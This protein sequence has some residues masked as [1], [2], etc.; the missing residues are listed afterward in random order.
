[1]KIILIIIIIAALIYLSVYLE[2]QISKKDNILSKFK[3]NYELNNSIESHDIESLLI[4]SLPHSFKYVGYELVPVHMLKAEYQFNCLI[5]Y[6]AGSI[7]SHSYQAAMNN[8]NIAYQSYQIANGAYQ[9]GLEAAMSRGEG[10]KYIM[11]NSSPSKPSKPDESDYVSYSSKMN[12]MSITEA[13]GT[14]YSALKIIPNHYLY[15]ISEKCLANKS[16]LENEIE[17]IAS[18]YYKSII[19][20]KIARLVNHKNSTD[21]KVDQNSYQKAY[22]KAISA[23]TKTAETK[24]QGYYY[25]DLSVAAQV[26]DCH[27]SEFNSVIIVTSIKKNSKNGDVKRLFSDINA[28]GVF[29]YETSYSLIALAAAFL[30]GLLVLVIFIEPKKDSISYVDKETAAEAP[31]PYAAADIPKKD[32]SESQKAEQSAAQLVDEAELAYDQENYARSLN[33]LKRAKDLGSK[34]QEILKRINILSNNLLD[35]FI[36]RAEIEYQ[37][38]RLEKALLNINA[39]KSISTSA[40]VNAISSIEEM[41]VTSLNE[42]TQS[43]NKSDSD[44]ANL[45]VQDDSPSKLKLSTPSGLLNS[46]MSNQAESKNIN[47]N[48]TAINSVCEYS[49]KKPLLC[50][51]RNRNT[52]TCEWDFNACGKP[53]IY[54]QKSKVTCDGRVSFSLTSNGSQLIVTDGCRAQFV[55][56]SDGM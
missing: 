21:I 5:K 8:Y 45:N 23:A 51:S 32:L 30:I 13:A 14:E 2:K 31:R 44:T 20:K 4:K 34:N 49:I 11:W 10:Q 41:I 6:R 15:K 28:P 27:V 53:K 16:I 19:N 25:A 3:K 54:R 1:M 55:P 47:Q 39:A 18:K 37:N 46:N 56:D 42:N 12:E 24:L 9:R 40:K 48:M 29:F 52:Q 22:E 50:E 38:N 43:I 26:S 17:F 35:A 7:D 33:I 36:V